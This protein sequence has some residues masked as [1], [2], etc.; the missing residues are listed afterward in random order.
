MGESG[1]GKTT[2]VDI[3]LGFYKIQNG[4]FIINN[5]KFKNPYDFMKNKV[6]YIP[7]SNFLMDQSIKLNICL[8]E[9]ITLQKEK[10]IEEIINKLNMKETIFNLPDNLNTKIGDKDHFLSGTDQEIAIARALYHER[11]IL[12]FDESTNSLD[13]ENEKI[14]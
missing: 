3:I 12:I 14:F 2:L 11:D 13:E 7:Q 6:A 1:S 9:N 10:K 4:E 5:K 8:E